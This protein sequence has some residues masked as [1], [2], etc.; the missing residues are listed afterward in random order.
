MQNIYYKLIIQI[1]PCQINTN[2]SEFD[3]RPSQGDFDT[4]LSWPIIIKDRQFKT[5][6]KKKVGYIF[7]AHEKQANYFV[8]LK[9]LLLI[10]AW[11]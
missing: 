8:F 4:S 9:N 10:M 2:I 5:L 3:S 1:Y 7:F 6:I 11:G